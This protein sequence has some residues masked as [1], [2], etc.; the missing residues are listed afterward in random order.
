MSLRCKL[1]WHDW[2]RVTYAVRACRRCPTAETREIHN[3]GEAV[4]TRG[5][6]ENLDLDHQDVPDGTLAVWGET[7]EGRA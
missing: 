1:G 4:R 5:P 3:M 7:R 6:A 2:E